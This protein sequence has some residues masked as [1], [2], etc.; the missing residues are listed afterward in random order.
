MRAFRDMVIRR[1]LTLAMMLTSV[2]T[3]LVGTTAW[4][5]FD[6]NSSRDR[7]VEEVALMGDM[8]GYAASP[9]IDFDLPDE[10]HQSLA[11]LAGHENVRGALV[12][13]SSGRALATYGSGDTTGLLDPTKRMGGSELADGRLRVWR[14][15]YS[16]NEVIATVAI[17]S[18]LSEIHARQ[19]KFLGV[20]ALVLAVCLMV[21]FG[22]AFQLQEVISRP[23]LA[24][25]NTM[26]T[27][28]E[29]GDFAL[30][31]QRLGGDEVGFLTDAFNEMLDKIQARDEE[32][33]KHGEILER[34][35]A[36]RTEEIRRRN[37]QLRRSMEEARSAAVAK[38]QFLA[39]MSHEI[40]TPMNGVLG[41][42]SLLLDT[43][44]NDQQRGYAELVQ[45]SAESLLGII[46]DIL[47]F[48]KIEA[49]KMSLEQ[50]EFN[51]L[52]S[53]EDVVSLLADTARKKG[54]DLVLWADPKIP[55]VLRGDPTRVRQIIT[56][57]IGNAL[58]F[59]DEGR[60]EVRMELEERSDVDARIKVS[61]A[62]SGIGI[63][64]EHQ[65]RLFQSFSQVDTS[66]T[67]KYGG[68]GLGLA[69]CKQLTEMMGG[70]IGVMS[71]EGE[72]ATFWFTVVLERVPEAEAGLQGL[73][74]ELVLERLFVC[75]RSEVV[76]EAVVEQARAFG[77]DAR[78]VE[79]AAALRGTLEEWAREG[80]RD[81][82]LLVEGESLQAEG[83]DLQ[84]FL[85]RLRRSHGLRVVLIGWQGVDLVGGQEVGSNERLVKPIRPTDLLECL[86]AREGRACARS[87]EG[88][89][90]AEPHAG[91]GGS[92]APLRLLLAEDNRINQLVAKKILQKGGY[93][94]HV[95]DDGAEAVEAVKTGEF[96]LV[97]MD[98]Q[99][100]RMDGFE[101]TAAIRA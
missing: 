31:A 37:R 15:V 11:V 66:T 49:G 82:V 80:G 61:V 95:T 36:E 47:D 19:A 94:C 72:G 53:V 81:G 23:I 63:P 69:I 13:D 67:R 32:L 55:V 21:A 46:G 71:Q 33:A 90:V 38:S 45:N 5:L 8:I 29:R 68:T 87:T 92:V 10:I 88:E 17:E 9:S 83:R 57:L 16:G 26:R 86:R 62:D 39:N 43:P 96:D 60:I 75:D 91:S 77:V 65:E 30:R 85:A 6:W 40:R 52:R 18:D 42:N 12:F 100:P 20:L 79:S 59:T 35:V 27:V 14:P 48:S 93:S 3:L 54:V 84:E 74:E 76:R 98:C 73:S 51:L 89:Q 34:E 7:L 4:L 99:M 25:A 44:L 22:A 2:L 70:G 28:S 50:I 58:K 41:M 56:N 24:L 101:A 1:K 64:E 97:L 78:S